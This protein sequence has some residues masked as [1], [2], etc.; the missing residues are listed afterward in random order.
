MQC[1]ARILLRMRSAWG[2]ILLA[3]LLGVP[4]PSAAGDLDAID[5]DSAQFFVRIPLGSGA[6]RERDLVYG[7]AVRGRRDYEVFVVDTRTLRTLDS[8]GAGIDAK[9]LL[10]GGVA[11][12][13]AIVASRSDSSAS[14]KRD[15]QIQQQQQQQRPPA[16]CPNTPPT[17]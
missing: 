7:F 4:A 14:Q 9:I 3:A 1:C 13:A 11:A 15:E 6:A 16:S 10:V 2:P 5:R 12:A 17:C 8:I